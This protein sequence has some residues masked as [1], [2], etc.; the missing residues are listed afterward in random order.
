MN[1]LDMWW[2]FNGLS[3]SDRRAMRSFRRITNNLREAVSVPPSPG[4]TG[5]LGPVITPAL[6]DSSGRMND[7]PGL[8]VLGRLATFLSFTQLS[9]LSE[10]NWCSWSLPSRQRGYSS[11]TAAQGGDVRKRFQTVK[12]RVA[13]AKK[14]TPPQKKLPLWLLHYAL[15]KS[16]HTFPSNLESNLQKIHHAASCEPSFER[17]C[18]IK[19]PQQAAVVM[20]SDSD[21]RYRWLFNNLWV[22]WSLF[23]SFTCQFGYITYFFFLFVKIL[24]SP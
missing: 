19:W 12:I 2:F 7:N 22:N 21:L 10:E 16:S 3:G 15:I 14:N 17:C 6:A 24:H 18:Q 9:I 1:G 11:K 23:N 5:G 8:D 13:V 4:L 20:H